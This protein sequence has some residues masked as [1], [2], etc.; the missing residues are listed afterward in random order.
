VTFPTFLVDEAGYDRLEDVC[1]RAGGPG[2]V[3]PTVLVTDGGGQVL[4]VLSGPQVETLPQ[5]LA[6]YLPPGSR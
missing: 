4:S 1:R 3:L 2:V 6:R 5:A